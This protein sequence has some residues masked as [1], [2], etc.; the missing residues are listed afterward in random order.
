MVASYLEIYN[1]NVR[2][3]LSTHPRSNQASC[4][5]K[6]KDGSTMVTNATRTTVTSTEQASIAFA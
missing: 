1:E 5:I 3:L 4:Q 6:H 2:D